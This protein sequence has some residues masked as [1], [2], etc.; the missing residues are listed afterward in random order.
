MYPTRNGGALGKG[1]T[2]EGD[3]AGESST[4]E[5]TAMPQL[6]VLLGTP[7]SGSAASCLGAGPSLS[8]PARLLLSATSQKP[9]R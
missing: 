1:L 6:K 9:V 5:G 3:A 2:G 8:L 7:S 4:V